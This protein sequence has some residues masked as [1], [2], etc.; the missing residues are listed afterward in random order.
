LILIVDLLD[1]KQLSF[2]FGLSLHNEV[3]PENYLRW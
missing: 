1:W 3:S 2:E